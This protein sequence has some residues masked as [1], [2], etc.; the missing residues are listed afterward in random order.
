MLML[1]IGRLLVVSREE[2]GR[3][4]SD[5]GIFESSEHFECVDAA[6]A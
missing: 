6:D 2:P 4:G 5:G 1:D 3:A